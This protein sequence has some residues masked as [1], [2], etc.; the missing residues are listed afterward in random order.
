MTQLNDCLTRSGAATV[1]GRDHVLRSEL[2]E[3]LMLGRD[4]SIQ[5]GG[6]RVNWAGCS[7]QDRRKAQRAATE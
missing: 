2:D 7:C 4:A 6:R 1:I 3:A 5:H